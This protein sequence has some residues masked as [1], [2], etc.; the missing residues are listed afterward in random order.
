MIRAATSSDLARL[1]ALVTEMHGRSEFA[2]RGIDLSPQLVRSFLF[3]GV[4]KHGG[5]HAGSTLLNVVEFRGVVE[6]FMFGLLQP[7][8]LVCRQLEAV[9]FWLYATKRAP[10]IAPNVLIDSYLAWANGNPRVRDVLL[11]WTDVVGVDGAKL[12][13][14]YERKGFRR[15]GEIF[16]R[17]HDLAALG[18]AA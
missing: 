1:F 4:R 12:A 13:K 9:D 5:D 11:S 3:D 15:R 17:S 7:V 6:A 8:Y 2:G 14:L 16:V 18:E 10:K